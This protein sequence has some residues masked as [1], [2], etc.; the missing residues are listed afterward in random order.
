MFLQLLN[1]VL[2]FNEKQGT[3][4][5]ERSILSLEAIVD[6]QYYLD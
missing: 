3:R 4:G 1:I 5:K 6:T 2:N